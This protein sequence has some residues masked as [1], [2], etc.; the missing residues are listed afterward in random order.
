MKGNM[1]RDVVSNHK[2]RLVPP[3]KKDGKPVVHLKSKN[4]ENKHKKYE[5]PV[6]GGFVGRKLAF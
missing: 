1:G 5:K 3:S 2:L 6:I 4:F